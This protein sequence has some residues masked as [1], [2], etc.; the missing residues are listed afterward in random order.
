MWPF[1][2]AK[3]K[4][5]EQRNQALENEL[6]RNLYYGTLFKGMPISFVDNPETLLDTGYMDN[7]DVF[8]II[9]YV[10]R[11]ASSVPLKLYNSSN[12]EITDHEVLELLERPN[13]DMTF[14]ELLEAF[15]IYKFS[16]GN[17][18]L[19]K[20]TLENGQNKGKTNEIWIMPGASVQAVSGSWTDP[21][22]GYKILEGEYWSEIPKQDVYHGKFF[23]PKFE[24]GSWVYGLSPIKVAIELIRTQ[25]YGYTAL[26]SSYLNGSPPYMIT[27]KSDDPLT[28]EQQDNLEEKYKD[29]Y[30]GADN[31]RKP[32]L[33][34]VPLDVKMLGL[35]PVDLN[36]LEVSKQGM[37][38]LANVLGGVPSVLLNDLDNSTYS[39]Y[40]EAKKTFYQNVI[41]PNNSTLEWGLTNWLLKPYEGLKF[42]FDYSDIEELQESIKEKTTAL[43]NAYYLTLNERREQLG[44]PPIEGG[45]VISSPTPVMTDREKYLKTFKL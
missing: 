37:R 3:V 36:I 24:N 41:M 44:Y 40:K 19:Y 12:D 5:L 15:Y 32:L 16:I 21:I 43:Q 45:D 13:P 27:T 38:T 25:N 4:Q 28:E 17:G 34:G 35:S 1:K 20:P 11:N 2:S 42:R 8:S 31:F 29:K 10:A 26:E 9:N 30:G 6:N 23:N 7:V 33:S 39:N 14:T 22:Q 18:Y